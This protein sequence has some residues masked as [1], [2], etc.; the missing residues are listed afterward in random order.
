MSITYPPLL[1][2]PLPLP[3]RER[4]GVR[5]RG[6]TSPCRRAA[7]PCHRSLIVSRR[8]V[9]AVHLQDMFQ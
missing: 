8:S 6:A 5:S 3:R 2:W 7:D 4:E 9:P 1:L